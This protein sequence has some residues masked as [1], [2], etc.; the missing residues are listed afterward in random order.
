MRNYSRSGRNH[1]AGGENA[2]VALQRHFFRLHLLIFRGIL[3]STQ[4]RMTPSL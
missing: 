3:P 2:S 4:L 1:P